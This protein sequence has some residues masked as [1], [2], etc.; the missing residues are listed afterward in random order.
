MRMRVFSLFA[1]VSALALVGCGNERSST[2]AGVGTITTLTNNVTL[3]ANTFGIT[4]EA[5]T[6]TGTDFS[7]FVGSQAEIRFYT[8]DPTTV[9]PLAPPGTIPAN[10]PAIF[11]GGSNYFTSV[12]GNVTSPTTIDGT[13][14]AISIPCDAMIQGPVIA[15]VQLIFPSG[16]D[17]VSR[18]DQVMFE[19]PGPPA[20]G[21]ITISVDGAGA[22]AAACQQEPFVLTGA[23]F[24]PIGG[25]V[26]LHWVADDP[27]AHPDL[28]GT[29][30]TE[31][32]TVATITSATTI[33][34]LTPAGFICPDPTNPA[35]PTTAVVNMDQIQIEGSDV[36]INLM[37]MPVVLTVEGPTVTVPAVFTEI[38]AG[39]DALY[40]TE[41]TGDPAPGALP[42]TPL[43]DPD[44]LMDAAK[45]AEMEGFTLGGMH[46]GPVGSEVQIQLIDPTGVC[47]FD[48]PDATPP[49]PGS[50]STT[51]TGTVV[52]ENPDGT[53]TVTGQIPVAG[54]APAPPV[55]PDGLLL[56]DKPLDV[57]IT[58]AEGCCTPS[59]AGMVTL[60]APPLIESVVNNDIGTGNGFLLNLVP[61]ASGNTPFLPC[62]VQS[63]TV[64]DEATAGNFGGLTSA[65][66]LAVTMYPTDLGYNL[67]DAAPFHP[68][69]SIGFNYATANPAPVFGNA[70]PH[71]IEIGSTVLSGS[72]A[73]IT[74][75]TR[76]EGIPDPS[77]PTA[78]ELASLDTDGDGIVEVTVRVTNDD[79]QC[80]ESVVDYLLKSPEVNLSQNAAE[81]NSNV[82]VTIDPTSVTTDFG[83]STNDG[84]PG[85][86]IA[87]AY[88]N[89]ASNQALTGDFGGTTLTVQSSIDGG[90][91]FA[92]TIINTAIDGLPAAAER[93]Y[94]QV[95]YDD[96]GNL[97]LSYRVDDA[98]AGLSHA[99]LMVSFDQGGTW[100]P[101]NG[102]APSLF[103]GTFG[104]IGRPALAVGPDVNVPGNQVALVGYT[105]QGLGFSHLD[106]AGGTIGGFAGAPAP[107]FLV[108]VTQVS[109]SLTIRDAK[110]AIGPDG[111]RYLTWWEDN[112]GVFPATSDLQ[113]AHHPAVAFAGYDPDVPVSSAQ[114][115]VN[116]GAGIAPLPDFGRLAPLHSI[117]VI[118]PVLAAPATV[119]NQGR[120]VIAFDAGDTTGFT[121]SFQAN[122]TYSD[123]FGTTWS[124]R[125][126]VPGGG[127]NNQFLPTLGVDGV[128]GDVYVNWYDSTNSVAPT[129]PADVERFSA[130]SVDG[131]ATF[132]PRMLLSDDPELMIAGDNEFIE[133]GVWGGVDAFNGCVYSGWAGTAPGGGLSDAMV[134]NY[135]Q[136]P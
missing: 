94:P 5:F 25:A 132:G 57:I 19:I 11:E 2:A 45:L 74:G 99:V 106:V 72:P 116:I 129:N 100:G 85:M 38:N 36:C 41:Y 22:T 54:V 69:N 128:T 86:N 123:D 44:P 14:P 135:Q 21:A 29:T 13:S 79:G 101:G 60:I 7:A 83:V 42:S 109:G 122:T 87:V 18:P 108:V 125:N 28:F 16:F 70:A 112:F 27:A 31:T 30:L 67:E 59:T 15:C 111:E 73:F 8:K 124:A 80:S 62:H 77:N 82:D 10:G 130:R 49:I 20:G 126:V 89:D 88:E 24:A 56:D 96:F 48:N 104:E 98:A 103:T 50:T 55:N 97:W 131:G 43:V 115:V 66:P 51:V 32:T 105:H 40:G 23:G 34:G 58:T 133:Y 81:I 33:E 64:N 68:L 118:R 4:P 91:T 35:A 26:F 71:W 110:L 127:S 46:L 114:G 107:D 92:P 113:I 63:M 61:G 39:T 37:M 134:V 119:P 120:V 121:N 47:V 136:A 17:I 53:G 90:V 78:V 95:E 52:T 93:S 117:E 6:L 102:I 12:M 3:A 76:I 75:D 9:P 84:T 1:L 65:F